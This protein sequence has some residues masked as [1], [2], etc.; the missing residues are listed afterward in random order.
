MSDS[1]AD[2][3]C[4][5]DESATL[6]DPASNESRAPESSSDFLFSALLLSSSPATVYPRA[7]FGPFFVLISNDRSH[8]REF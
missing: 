4:W 2:D 7:F 6:S 3:S 5:S 1:R 8:E